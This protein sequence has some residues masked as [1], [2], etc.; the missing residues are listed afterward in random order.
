MAD[1]DRDAGSRGEE[2][3]P[4]DPTRQEPT[5]ELHE[6]GLKYG[7]QAD[8]PYARIPPTTPIPVAPEDDRSFRGFLRRRRT[9]VTAAAVFGLVI[10]GLLGGT[11][12]AAFDGLTER[13]PRPDVWME[14]DGWSPHR[15]FRGPECFRTE[16]GSSC[17][18]NRMV[19]PRNPDDAWIVEEDE[20]VFE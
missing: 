8:Q 16:D 11:V 6:P 18:R 2:E 14:L 5:Q 4:R 20:P 19:L 12:V 10:G 17:S 15:D 1:H 7:E 3:A 9:Q 13:H